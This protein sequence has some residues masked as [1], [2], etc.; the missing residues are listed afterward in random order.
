[1]DRTASR[2]WTPPS[3]NIN[4]GG[5]G[6]G[7]SGS[8]ASAD[9]EAQAFE[10]VIAAL[11]DEIAVMG[12]SEKDRERVNALRQAGVTAASDEGKQIL[13]LI[14]IKQRQAEAEKQVQEARERGIEA[15]EQLGQTLDDQMLRIIDGTFDARDAV[16]ALVQELI[17]ASTN[18]KGLFGSL[19][20]AIAG[21][22]SPQPSFST[23]TTLGGFLGYG[24]ARAGGGDVSPGRIYRINEYED[25]LF[26]PTNHGRI[27]A[28]S[29]L[30]NSGPAADGGR[31][32]LEVRLGDGLVANILQQSADQSIELIRGNN[33]AQANYRQNGGEF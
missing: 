18:G 31:S 32:V 30:G 17:N 4:G 10:R 1:M 29:K 15:A 25:E 26:A 9:R 13:E 21:G 20:G 3:R 6:R 28:P 5:S 19:F 33:Q 11:R 23:N 16:A 7:R 22:F 24:G 8:A 27:V 12:L 2:E 14:D